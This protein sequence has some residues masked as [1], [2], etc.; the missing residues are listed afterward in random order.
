MQPFAYGAE[1]VGTGLQGE[2]FAYVAD[3]AGAGAQGVLLANCRPQPAC[4]TYA[5][6]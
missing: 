1:M 3:M 6:Q 5:L 2:P 4:M